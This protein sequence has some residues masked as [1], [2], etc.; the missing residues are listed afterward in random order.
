MWSLSGLHSKGVASNVSFFV[1]N[2]KISKKQ[3]YVQKTGGS[4]GERV[5]HNR[6]KG[7]ATLICWRPFSGPA[8]V[9]RAKHERAKK[10]NRAPI[11]GAARRNAQ[12]PGEPFGGV[13]DSAK[14]EEV[15]SSE[16]SACDRLKAFSEKLLR[17]ARPGLPFGGRRIYLIAS[18]SPPGKSFGSK[19]LFKA[20]RLGE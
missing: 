15:Q 7:A 3:N 11:L 6:K 8:S 2:P 12:G 5:F 10:T 20:Q 17:L 18:R 9:I 16:F 13:K 14:R 4:V 19:Q 1:G